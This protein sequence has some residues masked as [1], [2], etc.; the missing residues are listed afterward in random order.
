MHTYRMILR[1]YRQSDGLSTISDNF[2]T[3]PPQYADTNN[4][5]MDPPLLGP[6]L[7]NPDLFTDT[8]NLLVHQQLHL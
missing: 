6:V 3:L 2:N 5:P 4:A 8:I 1:T 7:W